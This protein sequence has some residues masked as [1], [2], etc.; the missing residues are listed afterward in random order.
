M[1]CEPD[2]TPTGIPVQLSKNWHHTVLPEYLR[3]YTL[4]PAAPG[5]TSYLLRVVYGFY[6]SLPTA[7]NSQLSLVGWGDTT[8]GRWDQL[9]I[10]SYGE[11]ICFNPEFSAST[12]A[13]TDVRSLFTRIG[14]DG[15]KWQ[16]SEAG[17]GGDWLS[18][19]DSSGKKLLL[20]RMKTSY[21]SHG[22]C[23]PETVYQGAYGANGEVEL[24][25]EISTLRTDDHAKTFLRLR[26]DFH[27]ELPTKDSWL[28]RLGTGK[29]FCPKIAF[30]HR[31]GLIHE[32]DA[33]K[34]LKANELFI[35]NIIL[36]GPSP[37][38]LGFPG[39]K[40]DDKPSGSRGF[41]VRSYRATFSG[42][43]CDSPTISLP[44][45]QLGSDGR[46]HV[47]ATIVP[48]A[49]I[50]HYKPGDSVEL[51][52]EIDV[53][54]AEVDD[55][56]GPNEAFR[57]HIAENPGS[58]KTFHRAAVANDL[59]VEVQGGKLLRNFPIIVK[60]NPGA[61]M[62]RLK[63]NGGAG[64]VPVRI[65]GLDTAKGWQLG[66]ASSPEKSIDKFLPGLATFTPSLATRLSPQTQ[67]LDQ[68]VHGNDFWET[69]LDPDTQTYSIT[70]NL[71]LD[72][73]PESTWILTKKP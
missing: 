58:W 73:K 8:N 7:S 17:W 21:L 61:S 51:D 67:P 40:V 13:I 32:L 41:V 36:T 72:G 39:S 4:L 64:A 55:Y 3:A 49:G 53:I 2:G 24:K 33:P 26:Y 50:A 20:A 46:C 22:P 71:P 66:G 52:I 12:S 35:K 38:W 68:S 11:T 16:W 62:L 70:Y 19:N 34:G 31:D 59:Q 30:G 48:P 54:P 57:Q 28:F 45:G 5:K 44:V 42:K 56:Y 23:L 18:V 9:A 65:E 10:G 1:L 43:T 27:A 15:K 60:A 69:T 63:I 25:A 37:W 29:V 47:D 6:G 14:K